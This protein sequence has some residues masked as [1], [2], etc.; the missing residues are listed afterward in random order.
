MRR[1]RRGRL[2]VTAEGQRTVRGEDERQGHSD[3]PAVI[4]PM[5]Q[6]L[7]LPGAEGQVAGLA[8]ALDLA[9]VAAHGLPAL[10]LA[11][12]LLGQAA[13]DCV[14]AVPLKPAARIVG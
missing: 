3:F 13:A 5:Q 14:A 9:D 12:V 11:A 6:R 1:L 10:D 4:S 7:P 2:A 8:V